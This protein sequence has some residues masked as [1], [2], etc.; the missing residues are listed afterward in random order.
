MQM[1]E[2]LCRVGGRPPCACGGTW[3]HPQPSPTSKGLSL[4]LFFLSCVLLASALT[5]CVERV[6]INTR[7]LKRKSTRQTRNA[8]QSRSKQLQNKRVEDFEVDGREEEPGEAPTTRQ[9]SS[10]R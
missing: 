9:G 7:F 6:V 8:R 3:W 1:M 5:T 10:Y 4:P 2:E